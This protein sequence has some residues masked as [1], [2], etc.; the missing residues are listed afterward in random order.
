AALGGVWYLIS[1]IVQT[2]ENAAALYAV[3]LGLLA[4][5]YFIARNFGMINREIEVYGE[6]GAYNVSGI[7][8]IYAYYFAVTAV[9]SVVPVILC[10]I[11]VPFIVTH[12][13]SFIYAVLRFLWKLIESIERKPNNLTEQELEAEVLPMAVREPHDEEFIIYYILLAAVFALII[14]FRKPIWR[15]IKEWIQ[16]LMSKMNVSDFEKNRIINQE[17]IS[18]LPKES[19]QRSSYRNYLKKSRRIHDISKRFLFAY[20]YLF[21]RLV[22]DKKAEIKSDITLKESLTPEE[23]S[24]I[25]NSGEIYKDLPD[26]T[27]VYEDIKYGRITGQDESLLIEMTEKTEFMLK[28]VL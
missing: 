24:N 13:G 6:N 12:I 28:E 17:I 22:K 9:F 16:L 10:F 5:S 11:I 14:L 3:Y 8:R 19:K 27:A 2:D 21:W 26:I 4:A 18:E 25:L 20:N 23:L 1:G 7:R 15:Q